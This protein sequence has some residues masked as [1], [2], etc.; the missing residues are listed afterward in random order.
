MKT[1]RCELSLTSVF[2]SVGV[3]AGLS[4]LPATAHA[5]WTTSGNNIYN[6]NTTTTDVGVGNELLNYRLDVA[7]QTTGD[8][9]Q[10]RIGLGGR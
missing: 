3:F 5:Q 7:T 10:I 8:T 2:K 4:L 9:T 1:N 6:T